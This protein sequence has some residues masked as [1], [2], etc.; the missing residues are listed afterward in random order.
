[1]L[2]KIARKYALVS[3][4]IRQHNIEYNITLLNSYDVLVATEIYSGLFLVMCHNKIIMC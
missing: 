1:M 4:I 2:I 3:A